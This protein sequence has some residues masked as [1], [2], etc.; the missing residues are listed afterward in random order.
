M[1]KKKKNAKKKAQTKNKAKDKKNLLTISALS[2]SFIIS[3]AF[4]KLQ[5]CLAA[6]AGQYG[7]RYFSPDLVGY[8]TGNS[9]NGPLIPSEGRSK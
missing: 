4:I 5:L 2:F 9:S 1:K 7:K 6:L 8:R 3:T